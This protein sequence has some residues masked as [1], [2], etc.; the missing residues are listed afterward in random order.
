M[1]K[2][3]SPLIVGLFGVSVLIGLGLWQ[4][5]RLHWKEALIEDLAI[6]MHAAPIELSSIE[7][8]SADALSGTPV[9]AKGSFGETY[10]DLLSGD[11][12]L[13]AGYRRV[14]P[15]V[16]GDR[17]VMVELGF[18][19]EA[20]KN[21]EFDL[22][23]AEVEITGHLYFPK[24]AN[25]SFDAARNIWVGYNVADMAEQLGAAPLILAANQSPIPELKDTPMTIDLP[26]NHLQ[27]A[28]TWFSLAAVWGMMALYW[29]FRRMREEV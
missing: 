3:L 17:T 24:G 15:F 16:S 21:A 25:G 8:A 23:K 22:P 19:P 20:K 12:E 6:K 2:W 18:L 14:V 7:L 11:K 1:S 9:I 27:Y 28:I 26:N 29:G 10:T 4:V 13:G 5:Q